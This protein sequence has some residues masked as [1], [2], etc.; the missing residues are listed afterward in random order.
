MFLFNPFGAG[1][2]I[3]WMFAFF[4]NLGC[5]SSILIALIGPLFLL[6]FF[7]GCGAHG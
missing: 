1:Q 4:S 2:R 5:L 7:R 3:D 6:A